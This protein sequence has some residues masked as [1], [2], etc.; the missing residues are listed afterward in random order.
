MKQFRARRP[1]N[2]PIT[3]GLLSIAALLVPLVALLF[4]RDT[5]E[6]YEALLWLLSLV[7]A[8]LLAYHRGWQ[9]A[10]LGLAVAMT[11]LTAAQV[12]GAVLEREAIDWRF[13]FGLVS[14]SLGGA[15]GIGWV[16][17]LLHRERDRAFS[18]A[19]TDELTGVANRRHANLFLE[20]EF[21]AARRGRSIV[22]VAFDLDRFKYFNDTY[23]HALGDDVLRAF[24]RILNDITR[25]SD[26]AARLG[27]EE[28]IA[29]LSDSNPAGATI[30]ADRVRER[31]AAQRFKGEQVTVSAGLAAYEESMSGIDDLLEAADRALYRAKSDGRNCVRVGAADGRPPG[32]TAGP[33][34]AAEDDTAGITAEG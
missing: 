3:A 17:E 8:F 20:R 25:R 7:P 11:V 9:G 23:G 19:L 16:T 4:F 33:G 1:R 21:A 13:L 2:V 5:S 32:E 14:V 22:V 24:G 26:L 29:I 31:L 27:G 10:A 15:F 30:F 34:D 18:L 6:E 12:A 28:F